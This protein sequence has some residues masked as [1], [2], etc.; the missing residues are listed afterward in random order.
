MKLL[1]LE[2]DQE[3]QL[4]IKVL[5][6]KVFEIDL[7]DNYDA[8]ISRIRDSKY[9]LF[10]VDIS[11][12][13]RMNGLD[14]VRE[15]RKTETY[16]HTPVACLTAHNYPK[17]RENAYAAGVDLFLVKP[18]HPQYLRETIMSMVAP[19]QLAV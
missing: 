16:K 12:R 6:K 19:T 13:G 3:N 9:D 14:F 11:L 10:I 1:V 2:D 15:L 8:A 17:D 18:I 7:V 4:F 5:L